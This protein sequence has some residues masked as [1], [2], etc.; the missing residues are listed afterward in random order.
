MILE[1]LSE[2]DISIIDKYPIF[3]E[4]ESLSSNIQKEKDCFVKSFSEF[5]S[6]ELSKHDLVLSEEI[7][8]S[9]NI[10]ILISQ[11]GDVVIESFVIPDSLLIAIPNIESLIIQSISKLPK[12]VPGYKKIKESG[13]LIPVTT[14]FMIPIEIKDRGN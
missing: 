13:E 9:I 4:C 3:K 6:N 2:L 14:K 12:I 8:A 7:Q 11:D 10:P 1:K 5:V